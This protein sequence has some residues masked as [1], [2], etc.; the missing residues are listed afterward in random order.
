MACGT[1]PVKVV[2][3]I[4]RQRELRT[5]CLSL[6]CKGGAQAGRHM[7][8]LSQKTAALEFLWLGI[9]GR[10]DKVGKI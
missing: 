10:A 8:V 4:W 3:S 9:S 5:A 6:V 7:A 2:S 1:K